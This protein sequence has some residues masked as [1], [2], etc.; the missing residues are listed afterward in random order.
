VIA[1][2]LVALVLCTWLACIGFVRLHTPLDRLHCVAFVNVTSGFFLVL[3]AFA[4]DGLSP[5]SL[6]ILIM[7]VL[8][9]L[10]GAAGAHV[11]GRAVLQRGEP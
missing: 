10:S 3:V 5:R 4:A 2:L 6:K 7:A 9:V 11:I 8:G 1:I